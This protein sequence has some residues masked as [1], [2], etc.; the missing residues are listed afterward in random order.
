[1][2]LYTFVQLLPILLLTLGGY[3]LSK[4][5][6]LSLDTLVKVI[7][8]FLMP[9]LIFHAL[10]HSDLQ[11]D[12]VLSIAGATTLIVALSTISGLL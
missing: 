4:I 9:L 8:D 6:E 5:Y 12:L 3:V 7:S 10:Y 2:V 1:M 11:G